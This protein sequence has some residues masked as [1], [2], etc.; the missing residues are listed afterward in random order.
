[1]VSASSV[2]W[3]AKYCHFC[4]TL[5]PHC[6]ANFSWC[7][8]FC[9]SQRLFLLHGCDCKKHFFLNHLY[10]LT[11]W[12]ILIVVCN[13]FLLLTV[14]WQLSKSSPWGGK[15]KDSPPAGRMIQTVL[16]GIR[17][18]YIRKKHRGSCLS[19]RPKINGFLLCWLD[20]KGAQETSDSTLFK[21]LVLFKPPGLSLHRV[22]R[23]LLS[24]RSLTLPRLKKLYLNKNPVKQVLPKASTE[25]SDWDH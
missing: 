13:W 22:N 18:K 19:K 7:C 8:H 2:P 15:M 17:G 9:T 20:K 3:T 12:A 21:E 10:K 23:I 11:S 25:Q 24:A 4:I 5:C 6:I 1:M 16:W 14:Y